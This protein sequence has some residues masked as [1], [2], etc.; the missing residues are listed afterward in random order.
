MENSKET[1]KHIHIKNDMDIKIIKIKTPS[2]IVIRPE[3]KEEDYHSMLQDLSCTYSK[4]TDKSA[5]IYVGIKVAANLKGHIWLRGVI[6]QKTTNTTVLVYLC[7][8]GENKT[9]SLENVL[10]LHQQF[11]NLPPLAVCIQV[12]SVSQH[13]K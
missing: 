9:L 5:Y 10:P 11:L 6:L 12:D 13:F 8:T 3:A 1:H 4:I 2:Q 7:D